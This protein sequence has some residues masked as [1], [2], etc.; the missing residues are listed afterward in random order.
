MMSI[1]SFNAADFVFLP[2]ERKGGMAIIKQARSVKDDKTYALKYPARGGQQEVATLSMTRECESLSALDHRHIVRLHGIGHDGAERFLVLE[3]L[4][5]TLSDRIDALGASDWETFYEQIGRPI[6]D[7]VRYAHDRNFVHRDL[8]PANVMLNDQNVPKITDFG[9]AR[10]TDGVHLGRTFMAAGSI[11]WTP[12]EQDDGMYSET[13]DIY[14]WAA[15]CTACLA[16]RQD[17]KT[18]QNVRDAA[19]QLR[20]IAPVDLLLRCLSD[21]PSQRPRSAQL[22]LWDLDDFHRERSAESGTIHTIGMDISSLAHQ[23]LSEL[24]PEESATSSRVAALISDFTEPCEILRLPNGE[25]EL[26]GRLFRVRAGKPVGQTPWLNVKDVYAA[27]QMPEFG[28]SITL[29]IRLSER[30]AAASNTDLNSLRANLSFISSFLDTAVLRAEQEQK[31]RD[32]ERFLIMHADILAARMRTLRDLPAVEYRRGKWVFGDFRV[33]IVDEET[34]QPGEQ[35]LIRTT[36]GVLLFEVIQVTDAKATLR[37]V[38]PTRVQTPEDGRL[39]VDTAAQK[40]ALERQ[41]DA[42][43]ILRN[44]QTVMPELKRILLTPGGADAPEPGGRNPVGGLSEDKQRVLDAALGMRQLMLVSG[45]PG[46]GKTTLITEFVKAYLRE[47]P[48]HRILIAAQ[49][50]IAIDHVVG[51]LL[52]VPALAERVVRVARADEEKVSENIRPALLHNRMVSWCKGAAA[53]SRQYVSARGASLGLNSQ[54]VEL[55][56]RLE[57]LALAAERL[58]SVESTLTKGRDDLRSANQSL[59][60]DSEMDLEKVESATI[61]TRTVAELSREKKDLLQK[62]NLL[63]D[64]L[65]S[66]GKDGS[67]LAELPADGLRSWLDVLEVKHPAWTSF[68]RELEVQVSWIDVLGEL[69]RIESLVLRAASV[70]AG[71]CVG[72]SGSEAFNR[73]KFDL[74]IIDEASKASATE[75][76]IPM[77]RS[78][79]CLLVGDLQ[80]LPPFDSGAIDLEGYAQAE[81]KETL[82][83]YL[84]NR[85]PK[86]CLFEL[87]HQHRMCKGIGELIGQV[88]Y[89]GKLVNTRSD[90]ERQAWIRLLYRKPVVWFD[91]KGHFQRQ[92][93]RTGTCQ[94]V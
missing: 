61:A 70:V 92:Q 12:P 53:K 56:V 17:F 90:S 54:E 14:S 30:S 75:A 72:L 93:G 42:V 79:Q 18:A 32:Q 33:E 58:A 37:P 31:A 20:G 16:G 13:R 60:L 2:S 73:S 44:E 55:S 68:R 77:V 22:V 82:L 91:T 78:A 51:K 34:L 87:T 69:R 76:M 29:R 19:G 85:L 74:C 81:M 28:P 6:L 8:K 47:H 88:F 89:E 7:A 94:W 24:L 52:G 1:A 36:E 21:A 11:P 23:H 50:H 48:E 57:M 67:M 9:I 66:L 63:R 41:E 45:P 49:T 26:S 59:E 27:A 38:G 46:T 4:E 84:L 3:W 40:K 62:L 86:G 71:T 35:R 25:L 83:E 10:V 39:L 65:R 64:E 15:L 43:K 80:Q 5:E